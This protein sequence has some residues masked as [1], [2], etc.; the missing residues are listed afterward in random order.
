MLCYLYLD[1]MRRNLCPHSSDILPP[2]SVVS[3]S[4]VFPSHAR[5]WERIVWCLVTFFLPKWKILCGRGVHQNNI[6]FYSVVGRSG[7]FLLSCR[8][9]W[10]FFIF[11][12]AGVGGLYSCG[13]FF[14][15]MWIGVHGFYIQGQF[16]PSYAALGSFYSCWWKWA[17]VTR[18]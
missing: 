8:G 4:G 16:L 14:T 15:L 13:R 1:F 9:E 18:W 6:I 12:W 3:Q 11:V 5:V 7:L 2:L 10:G 17:V